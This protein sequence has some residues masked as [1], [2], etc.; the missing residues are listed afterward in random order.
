[1]KNIQ[2]H[3]KYSNVL[4]LLILI[5]A[6]ISCARIE[7]LTDSE[8]FD[9][10]DSKKD[11]LTL[12]RYSESNLNLPPLVEFIIDKD[13]IETLKL[14]GHIKK[15]CDYTKI[16]MQSIAITTWNTSQDI[17][18]S[19]RVLCILDTR[20]I[21]TKS[22]DKI[23][24]FVAGGGTLFLPSNSEDKRFAFLLGIKPEAEFETD[25]T[26]AGY[27][28]N[29]A[30]L[31]GL[32]NKSYKEKDIHY[33]LHQ[34][35]FSDK[36]KILA[37]AS[38]NRNFPSI[39][40]NKI[41]NGKVIYYNSSNSFD[42]IDRGFVFSGILKGL[43]G[44]PYPIA[45]T[46]TIFLDDF[47]S[48]VYE[49]KMEP[50]ASE[51]NLNITDFVEKVWWPDMQ[52]LADTYDISYSAMTTF[53]YNDNVK[54]PF[55]FEQWEDT[56]IKKDKK[57]VGLS[58]WLVKEVR[59]NNHE[60]AF[61]GYNHVSLTTDG[62]KNQDFIITA[63]KTV[64]KKWEVNNYGPLPVT[65]VPPSNIIDREG[66]RQ[67]KKGMP[68]IKFMCSL[69]FGEVKEGENREF[70]FDPYEPNL[71]D[72]PRISSGF[73]VNEDDKYKIES[74]FLYTGIWNHFVHPD[75]VFQIADK[76]NISQGNY[77]LRNPYN[78]GWRKTKNSTRSMFSEFNELIKSTKQ[79]F[80]QIRF[81]N[82]TEGGA[83][84]NDWRA[85]QFNHKSNDGFYAVEKL[86]LEESITDKQYWF[87]YGSTENAYQ[88]EGQ[89]KAENAKF[90]RTSFLE[91]YLYSVYTEKPKLTLR[92]LNFKNA[93]AMSQTVAVV[94]T[95]KE[96]F[97]SYNKIIYNLSHEK[98]EEDTSEEDHK[99]EIVMLKEKLF[100]QT[101]IDTT[102][103][104][105][106]ATY[107]SWEDRGEEVWKL[108]EEYCIQ[109][110]S[111]ENVMYSKE[112]DKIVNYPNE[113][114]KEKW[115]NAQILVT[116]NDKDLLNS[117]VAYFNTP[118]NQDKI[119]NALVSLLKIDTTR[120]S[121]LK[122]IEYLLEYD[123]KNALLELEKVAP[124][125]EFGTLSN[126]ITWLY[127]DNSNFQKAY[128][129]S[130]LSNEFD[131]YTKMEWLVE[132]KS[133]PMVISEY[134]KH[135]AANPNDNK[136]KAMMSTVY[137]E[138]GKFKESWIVA[139]SMAQVDEKEPIRDIL[140]KDVVFEERNIQQDLMDNYSEFF[141]PEV[142]KSLQKSD[143]K[144]FGNFLNLT[145]SMDSNRDD[146]SA[147]KNVLSYNFYDKK[148]NLHSI[149]LTFSK[150]FETEI[151]L[152]QFDPD[153][154]TNT[155]YGLQYQFNNP[156]GEEKLQYWS[157]VR[158]EYS[159]F[160][161][162]YFQFGAGA[163]MS[164]DKNYKSLE[165]RIAPAETGASHSKNIY[166]FQLNL[167]Q[168][169]YFFK[170]INASLAFE[171]NFYNK[172]AQKETF[173]TT[174]E[175]YEGSSTGKIMYNDGEEKKYKFIP[176]IEASYSEASLGK[177]I[178]PLSEGYPYWLIDS[179]FFAGGGL[180]FNLG[181]STDDFNLQI[182]G[183]WFEDDYTDNFKRITGKINYQI[184]DYTVVTTS[185]E[186]YAQSK[187]YSNVIQFGV[188]H[189]LKKRK[190]NRN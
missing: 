171:G 189:N 94:A 91:G 121:Y 112:L 176:F 175:S 152:R 86:N 95:V 133:Y 144:E 108:L 7:N 14:N 41:G 120:E 82:T 57:I 157:S 83:I 93:D 36:I 97:Q 35:N 107:L 26:S 128:D 64:L 20:K 102:V 61:H 101:K 87:L 180:G 56:K 68:S 137:H 181:K 80:P 77:G 119:R 124:S 160:K 67:L 132:L 161:D 59:R 163:N 159:D 116:P 45:N 23:I 70:D 190:K 52:S 182:E 72:Y 12:R 38:N 177:S 62:W 76:N 65:Y 134:N 66:V 27:Y 154:V 74:L 43:E 10:F 89:L 110:P 168:E 96:E 125:D 127:A 71:F 166:R 150:M 73:C 126:A 117:Y 139:N 174:Q 2:Y 88:I 47:P 39:L 75:D 178:I 138:M 111:R 147:F 113:L 17:A 34:N 44:I 105:K 149:A 143:R 55:L 115:I 99:R 1:M 100:S 8:N 187:Y 153:N 123:S 167:Y 104:N 18:P 135:I 109:Y 136:A 33:G 31:P 103:W 98:I 162:Y 170:F 54:P 146:P 32:K 156:K 131:F 16:P 6:T 63:L 173:Y 29:V 3:I 118:E 25:I 15:V 155:L 172:S 21:S 46:S 148:L 58:N 22:I 114:V 81:L 84:V 186:V 78:L 79:S 184:F 145:S 92:D 142:L 179:R 4:M 106:Y 85:S 60:V 164:K 11:S 151:L 129:W 19:T 185:Y 5:V 50:I 141:Y 53:D 158:V 140:N 49:I 183:A 51:M 9:F 122:Y 130:E 48:P 165:L 30:M 37:T 13:N 188:K 169:Y 69:Y 90:K 40:E 28:F 24:E 42:K